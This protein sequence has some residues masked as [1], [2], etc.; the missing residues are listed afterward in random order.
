[1]K[2]LGRIGQY[3]SLLLGATIGT[4]AFLVLSS[5]FVAK[6]IKDTILSAH[7]ILVAN[8]PTQLTAD[9]TGLIVDLLQKGALI[10]SSDLLSN[11]TSFYSTVIQLLIAI[12]F[13]FG[14]LSFFAMR[15]HSRIQ[16]EEVANDLVSKAALNHFGSVAF[17]KEIRERIDSALQIAME[18]LDSRI[19][20]VDAARIDEL[21]ARIRELT[22]QVLPAPR[23]EEE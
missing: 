17:E 16:I 2:R 10:S 3:T 12:F 9:Q 23:E 5:I 21:E 13:V 7:G 1:M 11:M 19:Q 22:N 15:A 18:D 6:P 8:K 14:T 4:F 20:P